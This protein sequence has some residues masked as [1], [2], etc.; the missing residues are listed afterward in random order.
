MKEW[1]Y[2]ENL[3]DFTALASECRFKGQAPK[4]Y[5][6][7]V[8]FRLNGTYDFNAVSKDWDDLSRFLY[9]IEIEKILNGTYKIRMRNK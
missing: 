6:C 9:P 5:P 1:C 2:C 7:V 4:V 3:A 8:C